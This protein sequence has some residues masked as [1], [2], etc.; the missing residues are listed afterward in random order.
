MVVGGGTGGAVSFALPFELDP[1]KLRNGSLA[2][3]LSRCALVS[4]CFCMIVADFEGPSRMR[5]LVV[6]TGVRSRSDK[7]SSEGVEG[8]DN[9]LSMAATL[10]GV[11][12]RGILSV[13]LP[14]F[15]L[16][17]GADEGAVGAGLGGGAGVLG[18]AWYAAAFSLPFFSS[19]SVSIAR[20]SSSNISSR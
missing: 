20:T 4:F 2:G 8:R 15:M 9:F 18:G 11:L 14:I 19:L 13:A 5:T 1:N 12:A 10:A 17:E 16:V 6:T 3:G 7:V